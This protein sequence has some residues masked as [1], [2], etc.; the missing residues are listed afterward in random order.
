[1]THNKS[2]TQKQTPSYDHIPIEVPGNTNLQGSL[3]VY[4]HTLLGVCCFFPKQPKTAFRLRLPGLLEIQH[5]K[6]DQ[7]RPRQPQERADVHPDEHHE[8]PEQRHRHVPRP[9]VVGHQQVRM[10]YGGE[11]ADGAQD[12]QLL[13]AVHE[14]GDEFENKKETRLQ[15]QHEDLQALRQVADDN[16]ESC[17]AHDEDQGLANENLEQVHAELNH[18][19]Q[20][21]RQLHRRW[22][23]SEDKV[24]DDE[25]EGPPPETA[26]DVHIPTA[27]DPHEKHDD[28]HY[29]KRSP[30]DEQLLPTDGSRHK[31]RLDQRLPW[32]WDR[33]QPLDDARRQPVE[34][35]GQA[36]GYQ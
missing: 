3:S 25:S 27:S 26:E 16:H 32:I 6:L 4:N 17:Q 28:H 29:A 24:D 11:T 8:G 7:V 34:N 9:V 30:A 35:R 2:F 19:Q 13:T 5:P 33:R 36:A 20:N 15:K 23:A 1:M 31:L 18:A 12:R 10:G 14:A 21:G 22:F